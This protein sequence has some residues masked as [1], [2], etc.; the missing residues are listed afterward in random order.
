MVLRT[1]ISLRL[2]G[3]LSPLPPAGPGGATA[4][5]G[6]PVIVGR[7]SP[8]LPD[9]PPGIARPLDLK[10]EPAL[11]LALG[12]VLGTPLSVRVQEHD[13]AALRES[14]RQVSPGAQARA[15]PERYLGRAPRHASH[16]RYRSGTEAISSPEKAPA[17]P[18]GDHRRRPDLTP[19]PPHPP[20]SAP[21][22]EP[23]RAGVCQTRHGVGP[24]PPITSATSAIHPQG[25]APAG[26]E[27]VRHWTAAHHDN[28]GQRR[29]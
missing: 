7:Q 16:N 13:L 11:S 12:P 24:A 5:P 27:H 2:A 18:Q 10:V 9:Q 1:C 3:Q 22:G 23:H 20:K 4:F 6:G 21:A 29:C 25:A 14:R 15:G 28:V 26:G 17:N 19:L 8:G